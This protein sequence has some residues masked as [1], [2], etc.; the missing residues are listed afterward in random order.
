MHITIAPEKKERQRKSVIWIIAHESKCSI[1]PEAEHACGCWGEAPSEIWSDWFDSHGW[2]NKLFCKPLQL[3]RLIE[4][5]VGESKPEGEVL[6]R[7]GENIP[8][9]GTETCR[10]GR[11][12]DSLVEHWRWVSFEN[13]NWNWLAT[14]SLNLTYFDCHLPIFESATVISTF[15]FPAPTLIRQNEPKYSNRARIVSR[16]PL[17][18]SSTIA[19]AKTIYRTQIDGISGTELFWLL[20]S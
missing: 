3:C 10:L 7:N 18:W 9:G 17:D 6:I 8:G 5:L 15:T 20:Q 14:S 19:G 4:C 16:F 1:K 12:F 13:C 2:F 11:L